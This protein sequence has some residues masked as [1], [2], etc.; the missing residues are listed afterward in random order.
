MNIR[1]QTLLLQI[2]LDS[3]LSS[4]SWMAP[5]LTKRLKKLLRALGEEKRPDRTAYRMTSISMEAKNY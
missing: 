3:V 5:Y 2:V 1:T 4:M